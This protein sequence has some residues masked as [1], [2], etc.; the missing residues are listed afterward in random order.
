M[1][2]LTKILFLILKSIANLTILNTFG[3]IQ[4]VTQDIFVSIALR[5]CVYEC[6]KLW[7]VWPT[8]QF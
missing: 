4:K 3:V 8:L 5:N 7:Q 6:L 1:T 2:V